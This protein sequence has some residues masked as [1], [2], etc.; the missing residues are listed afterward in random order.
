MAT[1]KI[2]APATV[3]IGA[4]VTSEYGSYTVG[5]DGCATV[6]VRLFPQLIGNGWRDPGVVPAGGTNGQQLT[7]SG[8]D[9]YSLAW[10][11]AS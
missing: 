3:G 9:D 2:K 6:D 5:A 10:A 8:A 11:A 7:K 4:K 1:A